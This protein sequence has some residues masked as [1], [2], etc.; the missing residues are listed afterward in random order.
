MQLRR[1]RVDLSDLSSR[2]RELESAVEDTRRRLA[3]ERQ[4]KDNFEDLLTAMRVELEQLRN[5]RDHLRDDVVPT[6]QGGGQ[7]K[8]PSSSDPSELE[9]LTSEIEALKTENSSL[10]QLQGSRFASI[11]EENDGSPRNSGLGLGLSRSNSLAR[12]HSKNSRPS[13]LYG[14]K[15]RD[16]REALADRMNDVEAQRD[17]LHQSLRS[18]LARQAYQA[19]EFEK[20]AQVLG[21]EL[22]HAQQ[23]GS[24]RKLGYERDV[25]NLRDEVNHLRQRAEEALMQKWQCEKG[26]AGLKMDLDRAEQETASLRELLQEHDVSLPEN[27]GAMA[28][29]RDGFAEVLAT[30]SSLESA[31]QQLQ[32]DREHAETSVAQSSM[33]ATGDLTASLS[34]TETLTSSVR[35]QLE[36]NST[37]RDRLAAAIG[38][39]EKE[40]QLSAARINELQSQ[41]KSLEDVL[42]NAQQQSEEEMAKHEEEIRQLQDNHNDQLQRMKNGARSPAALSPR[43]PQSPFFGARSPR[44]DKT[45][46][47]DGIPLTDAIQSETLA[48]RVRELE[49]L[50]RNAD[51]EM[52]EVVGRMNR[53]Q[54]DVAELQSDRYIPSLRLSVVSLVTMMTN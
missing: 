32:T 26:L 15:E 30:S 50:L 31:Y 2:N 3:E 29:G 6:L 44:L 54:I 48:K 35:Q 5:E 43:P 51:L 42:L 9:R 13:S 17:A 38:K 24:P 23:V 10:A 18:L 47:G 12:G 27:S 52:E 53:A 22:A 36:T 34:R 20:R 45:T 8:P 14:G 40:Q 41:L 28:E 46:S 11:V 39:G 25:R 7:Y 1:E 4:I 33:D 16:T 37:L 21:L 49:R 19:G